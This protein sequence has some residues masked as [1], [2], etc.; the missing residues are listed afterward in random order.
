MDV[1]NGKEY[2]R[3]QVER[4]LASDMGVREW[5][6]LN[7]LSRSAMY[8]WLALFADTEPELFGGGANID[9]RTK[10]GWLETT[11]LSMGKSH[12]LSPATSGG[13]MLIDVSELEAGEPVARGIEGEAGSIMVALG[14]V[15]IA[16]PPGCAQVDIAHVLQAAS[17]F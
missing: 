9:D 8:R 14:R 11:R 2:R 10:H 4:L 7:H 16:I 12:A 3:T 6:E 1:Q 13:F 15:T 17:C 5:C